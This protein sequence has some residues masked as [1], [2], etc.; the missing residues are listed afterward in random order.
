MLGKH[1]HRLNLGQLDHLRRRVELH[2]I[3]FATST[4]TPLRQQRLDG[5]KR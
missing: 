2:Q 5:A 4:R 3:K 1:R